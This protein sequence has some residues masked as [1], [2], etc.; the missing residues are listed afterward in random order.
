LYEKELQDRGR[1]RERDY[2][3]SLTIANDCG[4]RK[5]GLPRPQVAICVI[6]YFLIL[7]L[8]P[9]KPTTPLPSSHTAPGMGTGDTSTSSSPKYHGLFAYKNPNCVVVELATWRYV[10]FV[11]AL[12]LK[13]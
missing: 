9:I 8:S 1:A 13:S 10:Y 3:R 5:G 7:L 4:N 11:Y 12:S 6:D 2:L